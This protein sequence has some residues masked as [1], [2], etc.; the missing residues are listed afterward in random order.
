MQFFRL[1]SPFEV[2]E[3]G[4]PFLCDTLDFPC[5]LA[6]ELAMACPSVGVERL[7]SARAELGQRFRAKMLRFRWHRGGRSRG[8]EHDRAVGF[9]EPPGSVGLAGRSDE[10]TSLVPASECQSC[11]A[12]TQ[13]CEFEPRTFEVLAKLRY[14]GRRACASR[15]LGD[16]TNSQCAGQGDEDQYLVPTVRSKRK[17]QQAWLRPINAR[18]FPAPPAHSRPSDKA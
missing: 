18:N 1:R 10:E 4:I 15:S 9:A 2:P 6:L 11:C 17:A 14:I 8:P 3:D 7:G 13:F 5:Q 16:D 12:L